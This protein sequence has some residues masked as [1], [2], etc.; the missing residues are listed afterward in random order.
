MSKS[1]GDGTGTSRGTGRG[2]RAPI[3]GR[4]GSE[5]RLGWIVGVYLLV[6]GTILAYNATTTA[7]EHD[8]A[9]V[10]N[11]AARQRAIAERYIKDVLLRLDGERAD[12]GED[13]QMLQ[14]NAVALLSGGTV[15][16]V[17]GADGRVRIPPA[18][19][20]WKVVAK[21]E[22]ERRL[23]AKL[24]ATGDDLLRKGHDHSDLSEGV[25]R[26]RIIGAQVS[27]ITNDAVGEM[28][29]DVESTLGRL[30]RV[31]IVLGVLGVL[32]A[33]AMGFLLRRASVQRAA[34]FR[35]L[36]HNASDLITVVDSDLTILYASASAGR[37]LG[38]AVPDL[39][40]TKLPDLVN[41][42]DVAPL[43]QALEGLV[44]HPTSTVHVEYRFR[45]GEGS[46]RCVETAA[47]NLLHDPL[48]RG[49]VLN[50]RDIT[51]RVL[52]EDQ[53]KRLQ[54]EQEK[55][56]ERTVQAT[57]QE[58]KRVA[59]ELHDGPVQHL[60]TLDVM[61]DRAR[62]SL[63]RSA[64]PR[65]GDAIEQ[66]QV[67]IRQEVGE[68][69]KMMSD[70]RPPALDNLG[71]V[72]AIRDHLATLG[73][74]TGLECSMESKLDSRL[75]PAQ[76]IVLYRVAQEALT[77][78]VKHAGAA[79][80]WVSLHPENGHV[81]LEVCD[82]G[83]GF[84]PSEATASVSSGHFGLLGMRERVDMAGGEWELSS[85]AGAG[86]IVRVRLPWAVDGR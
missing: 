83:A 80:I 71:V 27:T 43:E 68:L 5:R 47:T 44:Q 53:L 15:Q 12:P 8:A 56:L 78:I 77:N 84:D 9:L 59:A 22:Q 49:M 46:W 48:V 4:L 3:V 86:T 28:T 33:L 37:L 11:I 45:H 75:L 50:T 85:E 51:E 39:V 18:S 58:R 20:N 38:Y 41:R 2:R 35:S 42:D 13:G 32:A 34:Q 21:L 52:A 64:E 6:I 63:E 76:E 62:R 74:D 69:R 57:E 7:N 31:G 10:V 82:D 16:A 54:R 23:I 79:R 30:V 40:G 26:L 14:L 81:V 60:T 29:R 73:R 70:L 55:L 65:E 72:A 19:H 17:Q 66:V 67:R 25:L 24:I 36:I 61:L 1:G